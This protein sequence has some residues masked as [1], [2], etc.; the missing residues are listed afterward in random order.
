MNRLDRPRSL[1]RC[2][3]SGKIVNHPHSRFADGLRRLYD[4]RPG[5]LQCETPC[6]KSIAATPAFP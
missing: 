6:R 2:L 1:R 4:H 5:A 3:A